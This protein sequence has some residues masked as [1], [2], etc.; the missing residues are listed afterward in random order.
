MK[1]V[2]V[3]LFFF[4]CGGFQVGVTTDEIDRVVHEA[5]IERNAYPSPL[6]YGH[7]PKSCCTSVNEVHFLLDFGFLVD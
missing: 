7:F 6:G 1:L 3:S 4:C 2:C 5:C